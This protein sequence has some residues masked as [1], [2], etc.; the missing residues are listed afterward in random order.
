MFR[1][2]LGSDQVNSCKNT[3]MNEQLHVKFWFNR[4]YGT[5]SYLFT[6]RWHDFTLCLVKCSY[7]KPRQYHWSVNQRPWLIINFVCV[8]V[9]LFVFVDMSYEEWMSILNKRRSIRCWFWGW[10][11]VPTTYEEIQSFGASKEIQIN[12]V[13]VDKLQCVSATQQWDPVLSIRLTTLVLQ[14]CAVR[15]WH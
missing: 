8:F 5:V 13:S 11:Y 15:L 3:E 4:K 2:I 9:C 14:N 7:I 10:K 6:N 12:P 1:T